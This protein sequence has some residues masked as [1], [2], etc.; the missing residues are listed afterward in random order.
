MLRKN[1]IKLIAFTLVFLI[2]Q[3]SQSQE[4]GKFIT[5]VKGDSVFI[6]LTDTPRRGTSFY[7]ERTGPG[8]SRF[9]RLTVE[10]VSGIDNPEEAR[11]LLGNNYEA[12]LRAVRAENPTEMLLRLR[13]NSFAG[14]VLSLLLSLIH[15]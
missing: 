5:G 10:P 8:E 2:S 4:V 9:E 11:I 3:K 14:G 15:I 6:F 12:V 13:G 1:W 7:V